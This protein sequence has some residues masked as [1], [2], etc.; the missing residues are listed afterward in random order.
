MLGGSAL[1]RPPREVVPGMHADDVISEYGAPKGKAIGDNGREN[2]LYPQFHL[3]L[4][5]GEVVSVRYLN[6]KGGS[7]TFTKAESSN[8]SSGWYTPVGKPLE[9]QGLVS[10]LIPE[11]PAPASASAPASPAPALPA[12]TVVASSAGS[13]Q[14]PGKAPVRRIVAT[15]KSLLVASATDSAGHYW[16]PVT[17]LTAVALLCAILAL[18]VRIA[19]RK[20]SHPY[21]GSGPLPGS[22][23]TGAAV[24]RPDLPLTGQK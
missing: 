16:N 10:Q 11:T 20:R 12:R 23:A 22:S 8:I 5:N 15:D 3:R 21:L 14:A 9:S 6:Q 18:V 13:P 24:K 7:A 2:W 4:Q 17:S 19:G 1:A